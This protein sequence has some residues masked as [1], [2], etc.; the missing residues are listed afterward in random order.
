MAAPAADY[1]G[2]NSGE[3]IVSGRF[4][5]PEYYRNLASGW[6]EMAAETKP[7]AGILAYSGMALDE[8]GGML[9]VFGGGHN[10]YSGNDVWQYDIETRATWV[11]EYQAN[12]GPYPTVPEIEAIIDNVNWGG[13]IVD[14]ETSLPVRPISRHTYKSVHWM[15]DHGEM[16]AGGGSLWAGGT[17]NG[18]YLWAVYPGQ[19]GDFWTYHASDITWS[20]KGA[21]YKDSAYQSQGS[22][23]CYHSGRDRLYATL[24]DSN[25][26]IKVREWNPVSNIWADHTSIAAES[27]VAYPAPIVD[28]RRDR[29]L[30]VARDFSSASAQVWSYELSSQSF[31]LLPSHGAVPLI[32][33]EQFAAVYS[34][35][36]DRLLMVLNQSDGLHL[37]DIVTGVWSVESMTLVDGFT[38]VVGA[39][40]Y[41]HMRKVAFLA[42][43]HYYLG[44]RLFAYKE[45]T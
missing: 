27:N 33:D 14:T 7:N 40:V 23:H 31:E 10:D 8:R 6:H 11:Q 45:S 21:N 17:G 5:V 12:P 24:T 13:A 38:H 4:S 39:F 9:R 1:Y 42:Y 36:T 44:P 32:T 19:F 15:P 28:T 3:S 29:L 22:G 34:S 25:W 41:D 2:C 30:I 16:T 18:D 20:Y 26:R 35:K 43:P 37:Y